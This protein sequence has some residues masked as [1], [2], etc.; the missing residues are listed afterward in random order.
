M[1]IKAI[2]GISL[3]KAADELALIRNGKW[4]VETPSLLS[5]F[6]CECM[7]CE[8]RANAESFSLKWGAILGRMAGFRRGHLIPGVCWKME[9]KETVKRKRGLSSQTAHQRWDKGSSHE[10]H[11][12]LGSAGN[13]SSKQAENPGQKPTPYIRVVLCAIDHPFRLDCGMML[14]SWG[15]SSRS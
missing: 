8:L 5:S 7:P 9:G 1:E 2:W 6:V 4:L 11:Y 3:E 15:S 12:P 14:N 10:G 13:W